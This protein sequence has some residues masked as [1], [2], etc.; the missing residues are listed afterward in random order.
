MVITATPPLSNDAGGRCVLVGATTYVCFENHYSSCWTFTYVHLIQTIKTTYPTKSPVDHNRIRQS[1]LRNVIM[2]L[3]S[4]EIDR[5]CERLGGIRHCLIKS[6]TLVDPA[7]VVI[8]IFTMQLVMTK[9]LPITMN[10][11]LMIS[12]RKQ[13]L[14]CPSMSPVCLRLWFWTYNMYIC[15]CIYLHELYNKKICTLLSTEVDSHI[16]ASCTLHRYMLLADACP[17]WLK[18]K[19]LPKRQ[20]WVIKTSASDLEADHIPLILILLTYYSSYTGG[21]AVDRLSAVLSDI[22]KACENQPYKHTDRNHLSVV[23][24][25]IRISC[26]NAGIRITRWDRHQWWKHYRNCKLT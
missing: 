22:P 18:A 1:R 7:M 20:G 9:M 15:M 10:M 14:T 3:N 13:S 5:R 17:V 2:A 21:T 12:T 6:N 4:Q 26:W 11:M 8:M 24:V 23:H 25:N 19:T 16:Y